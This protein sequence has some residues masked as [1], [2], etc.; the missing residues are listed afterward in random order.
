[1]NPRLPQKI[2]VT[3]KNLK[4]NG[5]TF[6]LDCIHFGFES[7]EDWYSFFEAPTERL[8]AG[9]NPPL[10]DDKEGASLQAIFT[11]EQE[12]EFMDAMDV[13]LVDKDDANP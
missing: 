5:R 2:F 4:Y 7:W 11:E 12:F 8:D 3:K 6:K 1:M 9:D 10:N 13:D